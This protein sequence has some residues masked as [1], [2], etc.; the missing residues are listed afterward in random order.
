MTS[1]DKIQLPRDAKKKIS[2]RVGA[3]VDGDRD[4]TGA[5][6]GIACAEFNG[7]ITDRLLSGALDAMEE[8]GCDLDRAVVAW[9]PGAFE[10][11]L[12]AR[13]L[14][15][16]GRVDAVVC[17]GAVIRGET[18]HYDFVAGECASGLQRVQ[19]DTGVPVAFGVLTTDT[20]DQA[21]ARSEG[22]RSNKGS[23]AAL[24]A[25]QMLGVLSGVEALGSSAG[26]GFAAGRR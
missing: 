19:L 20:V 21:L 25:L 8:A 4:S 13:A 23:E 11:P 16:S 10:L 3:T 24:T 2:L 12:V 18:G 14:A 5:R 1:S 7:A 15:R 17:L 6:M 26:V 9:V 22:D